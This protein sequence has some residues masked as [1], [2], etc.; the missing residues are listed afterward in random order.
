MA[1]SDRSEKSKK[2]KERADEPVDT[3]ATDSPV[4]KAKTSIDDA[5]VPKKEKKRSK[6]E[7]KDKSAPPPAPKPAPTDPAPAPAAAPAGRWNDWTQADLGDSG[8]QSK[9]LRLLGA[10]KA[11]ADAPAPSV[12]A[13]TASATGP[14]VINAQYGQR[15]TADLEKQLE[16]GRSTQRGKQQGRSRGIGFR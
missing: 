10:K 15:I 11:G 1:P 16:A 9:F 7:K 8:R 4:K 14:T 5:A 13:P 6:K 2:R 12:A 3:P